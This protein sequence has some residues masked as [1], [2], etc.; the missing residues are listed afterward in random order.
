[1]GKIQVTLMSLT[2]RSSPGANAVLKSAV[3]KA[4]QSEVTPALLDPEETTMLNSSSS[5]SLALSPPTG[6]RQTCS[7]ALR[8]PDQVSQCHDQA[9]QWHDQVSRCH[10]SQTSGERGETGTEP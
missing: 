8:L 1:M 9:S 7:M 3:L 2:Y 5:T 4:L 10:K 6:R